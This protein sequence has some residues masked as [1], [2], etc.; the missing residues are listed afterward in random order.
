MAELTFKSAGVSTREID[1]SGPTPTG[2]QGVPAGIIGTAVAGPAFVPIT[3]AT[4]S[5]FNSIFGGADGEKFGPIAVN[6]WLKSARSC[7]Y[8]RVLGAGDGKQ[9]STSGVVT[10][11]G[12]VVGDKAVQANG[13]VGDNASANLATPANVPAGRTYFLGAFHSESNGSTIFSEAGIQSPGPDVQAKI[14][15]AITT[16]G[17]SGNFVLSI[18]LPVAAGGEHDSTR[19]RI[20]VNFADAVGANHDGPNMI[21][22]GAS[23]LSASALATKIRNV[24]NGV[25]LDGSDTTTS[26]ATGGP[27]STT[28]G[29]VGV[30]AEIG[31]SNEKITLI[32]N[33]VGAE[34]NT[35]NIQHDSGAFAP[36]TN[37]SFAGGE[38]V[39]SV[40][41]L[42]GVVLAPSG[43]ILH[44]SGNN[45]A[46]GRDAAPVA[47]EEGTDATGRII[48]RKGGITGSV[49]LSS[50]EFVMMLNG[51]KGAVD[52]PTVITASF[53]MTAPNYFPNVF[54]TDPLKIEEKGHYLYSHYD[55]YPT[56]ANVTGSGV[57]TPGIE[58][59]NKLDIGFLLTGSKGRGLASTDTEIDYEDFQDRFSAPSSPF[60]ISQ[61]F[62]DA[63]D[64]F[65][66]E[67]INDGEGDATRIKISIENLTRSTSD[68]D[69]FGTFDLIVRDFADTDD[70][71]RVL[72]SFRGLSLDPGSARYVARAIGDQKIFFNFD[73][74]LES[75]KI[76]VDGTHP[77]RSR[78]IRVQ[79]SDAIKKK[80]VP[81][82]ALPVGFR[83]P[84]HLVTS[85]A[86]LCGEADS[87]YTSSDFLQRTVEPPLPYRQNIAVGTGVTKRADV[88]FFWGMQTAR[89]TDPAQPNKISL[90]D[91]SWNSFVKHF[92]THRTDTL[93]FS[94]GGNAGTADVNGTVLDSDRF[95]KNMFSL[96]NIKVHTGSD[97]LARTDAWKDAEYIRAGNISND[98]PAKTRKFQVN[99]L[100]SV[101]NRK[102]AKFTF[103]LQGG[104]DGTNIFNQEKSKLTNVAARR[105]MVDDGSQGGTAGSTVASFRKAIDIM[106]SK[107]DTEIQLL[108]IPGMR[109]PSVT[110][111]AISAVESRFDAMY[112][113][114]IE[115]RDQFNTVITS[116]VQR[117]HVLNT[118]SD[119]KNRALDTSFAATYFPDVTVEDPETRALVS[120]PPSVAVLGAYALN[121][122][123]GHPWFAPAG[124][125]RGALDAVES[126]TVKLN[127]TNLDDLYDS[128]INPITAFPGT[129]IT[130]WGQKTLLQRSSALDRVNVRRLLISVRRSVRN[131][132]NTLLFEPNREETLEKFSSLVNPVLQRVQELSGVD[133]YKVIID[134]TTTTQADVENNTIRGKIFLQPTRT[135]EFVALDFVV[136]NAGS[137]LL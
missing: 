37:Q 75:Q 53:D 42:R 87:K 5:E 15:D 64:L 25:G 103:P 7:T 58:N 33:Q 96:E 49:D 40:P 130:V 41:I 16:T 88:R 135:V 63:Y 36:C 95:N 94:V 30:S 26:K 9:R 65:K 93:S 46:S 38:R 66:V 54:N 51:Y 129:G 68:V 131:I 23:G 34:G 105:E 101:S 97:K 10:N 90:P 115:E 6:E 126:T 22:I 13:L 43:V 124:F 74:D 114:D 72:E 79:L 52:K 4:F 119:L 78:F 24:I 1:L 60:V 59:G 122:R 113:M 123:I 44:L 89:K 48:G 8:L 111:F 127:R 109:H 12:F 92:P 71:K 121:D 11:A 107:S 73:N 80:E 99:D 110:D 57:L 128:D 17:A 14:V 118:V 133:R 70:E 21:G 104:F 98:E 20:Q 55:L 76:I 136:T 67:S 137:E 50:Q 81:D 83:G 56:M 86:L 29:V 62:S 125:S 116:S 85:G 77:V 45:L 117:P 102:Y 18:L 69:K 3:F 112:I 132:A 39:I 108:T 2:P 47:T 61:V 27:G 35:G 28:A 32:V 19:T 120:V 82:E 134:T 100:D 91:T 106:G 84:R 31:S